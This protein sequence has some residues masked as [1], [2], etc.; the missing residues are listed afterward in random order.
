MNN[1]DFFNH[2]QKS[3]NLEKVKELEQ[4][5][6]DKLDIINLLEEYGVDTGD[7]QK[8]S[9]PFGDDLAP[10][11]FVNRERQL[12]NDF[13]QSWGGGFVYLYQ[14]LNQML[15]GRKLNYYDTLEEILKRY[16]NVRQAFTGSLYAVENISTATNMTTEDLIKRLN[17]KSCKLQFIDINKSKK[18]Q[19]RK[20]A[21]DKNKTIDDILNFCIQLQEDSEIWHDTEKKIKEGIESNQNDVSNQNKQNK[22]TDPTNLN[23][24]KSLSE[25]TELL[26]ADVATDI[27]LNSNH[28]D[29]RPRRKKLTLQE[30]IKG[31]E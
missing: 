30:L 18:Y 22:S 6:R 16:P 5:I 11:F 7:G 19:A 31:G 15:K 28:S 12:W 25:L 3:V 27:I 4:I 1:N 13:S 23:T 29:N 9:S 20:L 21:T 24:V 17:S 10:S 26:G 8:M 2:K 14:K